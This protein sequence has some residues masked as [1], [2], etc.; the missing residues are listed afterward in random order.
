M[1]RQR[2]P[3]P[4]SSLFFAG[5]VLAISMFVGNLALAAPTFVGRVDRREASLGES[6]LYEVTLSLEGGRA[7]GYKPPSFRGFR[8]LSER[9]GQSTQIQMGGG[10][11]VM[12][13]VYTWR[14][15]LAPTRSGEL[16][17]EPATIRVGRQ[18]LRTV[19]VVIR[20]DSGALA[21]DR[22]AGK[23]PRRR[24]PANRARWRSPLDDFFGGSPLGVE[25][26]SGT[27]T[28]LRAVADKTKVYLGEQVLVEWSLYY[29]GNVDKYAPVSEPQ[30]DGFWIE[31]LA[32]PNNQGNLAVTQQVYQG[33]TYSVAVLQRKALFP[34]EVGKLTITPLKSTVSRMDVFGRPIRT[35]ALESPSL[36][37]EVVP[38]PQAGQPPDFDPARVGTYSLE[39]QV[40]R[41]EV[42][43]GEAVTLKLIVSG[44]GNLRK[45]TPPALPP[46]DGWKQYEPKVEV[47]IENQG[48]VA[49]QKTVEYLLLPERP[50]K[51]RIPAFEMVTF[52][53]AAGRYL[54]KTTE[55]IA[56]V[57]TGEGKGPT[58]VASGRSAGAGAGLQNVLST[59]IRP[60]R[61]PPT[62]D[63][64]LGA[65]YYRSPVFLWS[66]ILPPT[67]FGLTVLFGR[68][69][70]RRGEDSAQGRRK[71]TRQVIRQR[72][73]SAQV[74][75]RGGKPAQFFVEI[76]KALRE[77]LTGRLGRP[78][79]GYSRDELLGALVKSG[80]RQP[81]AEAI[82]AQLE[83]CDHARFAPGSTGSVE[84][85]AVL[86]RTGELI[87]AVE[88][89]PGRL[90]ESAA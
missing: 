1:L 9:P 49:G 21:P 81:V 44:Q 74:Q 61:T 82:I 15:E 42:A 37:I 85:R 11:S 43:V 16:T 90:S 75:L 50:G 55:P 62:L 35:T 2:S 25:E 56:L 36:E 52:D 58:Q 22:Q 34:L 48:T 23:A 53:P 8:V 83:A 54:T 31:E 80:L 14:Y 63:R 3:A 66:V 6:I 13:I 69:R 68:L 33:R 87:A 79:A 27:D 76:D 17:I 57:V 78:V 18:A 70:E 77:A 29:P 59:E 41:T 38:L 65:T 4:R 84:M 30:A 71:R 19:P 89:T 26:P 51:T 46:I 88:K 10:R 40:D 7:Q 24:T 39:V 86:E 45:L 73:R 64:D 60:P 5:L 28:F 72:L 47:Q 20:V 12:R 67:F 32:V